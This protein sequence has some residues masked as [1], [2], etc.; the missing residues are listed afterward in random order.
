MTAEDRAI[1]EGYAAGISVSAIAASIGV[2]RKRVM[3]RA[4]VLGIKHRSVIM[5]LEERFWQFV[6][7]EPNTGCFL[8]SGASGPG[9]YGRFGVSGV[10][11]RPAHIALELA[12]R[13]LPSGLFALHRCDNP[14]CVN[15]DHLF[16]GT[17]AENVA[18]MLAKGRWKA[19][20][21][22]EFCLR[23]HPRSGE[24]LYEKDGKGWCKACRNLFARARRA[25]L[26]AEV[27]T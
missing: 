23:G 20:P 22:A 18:D 9:G 24:N 13:P 3:H 10:P 19:T 25:R 14:A 2:K 27:A 8:W 12:G 17:Q 5:S 26:V 7:P 6:N 11:R 15:P 21:H 1:T 4:Q 16:V